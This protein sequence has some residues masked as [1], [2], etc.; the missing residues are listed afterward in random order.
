VSGL[1]KNKHIQKFILVVLTRPGNFCLNLSWPFI[2][3]LYL[4]RRWVALFLVAL[5]SHLSG[6]IY[7][8][9]LSNCHVA[10]GC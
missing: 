9:D 1:I 2:S 3:Y 8:A 7:V 10:E 5:F 4:T 6:F